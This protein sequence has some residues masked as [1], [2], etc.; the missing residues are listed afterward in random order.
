MDPLARAAVAAALLFLATWLVSLARR[1]AA[2]R[3]EIGVGGPERT[4]F[5]TVCGETRSPGST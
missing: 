3:F 4:R 2:Q 1:D 5:R